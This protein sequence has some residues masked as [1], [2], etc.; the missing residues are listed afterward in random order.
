MQANYVPTVTT[1]RVLEAE[2]ALGTGVLRVA[3]HLVKSHTD[4]TTL[5]A[6]QPVTIHTDTTTLMDLLRV[7]SPTDTTTRTAHRLVIVHIL[8]ALGV[9]AKNLGKFQIKRI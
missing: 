2:L 3:L 5:T 1:V 9:V 4:T 8:T 6:R 7:K